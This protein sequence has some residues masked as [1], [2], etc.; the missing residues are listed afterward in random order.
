MASTPFLSVFTWLFTAMLASGSRVLLLV[1]EIC[2]FVNCLHILNF[3]TREPDKGSPV[4]PA[5]EPSN[6]ECFPFKDS[7][8]SIQGIN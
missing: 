2:S 6:P 3:L 4:A 5:T 7:L 8:S 1:D